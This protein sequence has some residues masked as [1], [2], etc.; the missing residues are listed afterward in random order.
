MTSERSRV[1][2]TCIV[3]P[4]GC[5]AE[6]TVKSRQVLDVKGCSCE[7]GI[8]YAVEEYVAPK[9]VLTTS[10]RIR[11]GSIYMLPVRTSKPIPRELLRKAMDTLLK[12]EVVAPVKIGELVLGN[13]LGT[14]VDV[15]A[16]RSVPRI[17]SI[18]ESKKDALSSPL[19]RRPQRAL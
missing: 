18:E 4:I 15:V 14:G 3:C 10:V 6:L 5:Q 17:G 12:V 19:H 1:T 2:V 13:L 11:N 8:A 7:R 9:R 16:S